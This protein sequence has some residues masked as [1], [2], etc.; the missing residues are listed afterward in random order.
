TGVALGVGALLA[1]LSITSGF[2][3]E[4]RSKVL[5]VNA[6][7]LVLKYGLDFEEYRDVMATAER[8]PAVAAAAPFV[9]NEMMIAKGDSISGVLV[10][11][12]D[13]DRSPQVLDLPHQLVEGS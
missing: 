7:V 2:Q 6:H 10:K 8:M 3:D 11:G 12:I 1:V 13:P 5:G 4:F 9:I